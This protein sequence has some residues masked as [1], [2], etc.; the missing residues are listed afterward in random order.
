MVKFSRGGGHLVSPKS[1]LLKAFLMLC[2]ALNRGEILC[3]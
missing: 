2:I 1:L 3:G